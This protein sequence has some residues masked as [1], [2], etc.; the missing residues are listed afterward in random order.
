MTRQFA[1]I[2]IVT[3]AIVLNLGIVGRVTRGVM[4]LATG[5]G[6]L[7][8]AVFMPFHLA[9]VVPLIWGYV[10]KSEPGALPRRA[11][12]FAFFT[13]LMMWAANLVAV[14]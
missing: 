11:N 9:A 13:M 1:T 4:S 6:Q 2:A 5:L 3:L 12:C 8:G 14:E 10:R 7:A